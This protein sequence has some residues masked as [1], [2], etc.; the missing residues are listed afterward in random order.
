VVDLTARTPVKDATVTIDSL[1]SVTTRADGS[2]EVA[3]VP[4]GEQSIRVLASGYD[5]FSGLFTAAP[6][7]ADLQVEVA[8]T[9]SGP[10]PAPATIRGKVTVRNRAN[11]AGVTV[12]G[13][14][15]AT[16]QTID[17]VKTGA[18][19]EYGLWVPPGEY[20]VEASLEGVTVSRVVTLPGGGRTLTG[21]DFQ[22]TAP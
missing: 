15:T 17:S 5:P 7:M 14:R 11:N 1:P 3:E 22:I 12:K 4:V 18:S 16:E 2:F 20:R 6:D 13:I 19:G 9:Q 21:I 8:P 10:P